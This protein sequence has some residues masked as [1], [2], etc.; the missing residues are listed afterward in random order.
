M[1]LRCPKCGRV[2]LYE[3]NPGTYGCPWLD[4]KLKGY[5]PKKEIYNG[6]AITLEE[7]E[8][9]KKIMKGIE[10]ITIPELSCIVAY[11]KSPDP[12]RDEATTKLINCFLAQRFRK[13]E[14]IV[15]EFAKDGIGKFPYGWIV[16]KHI[17]L[18]DDRPFNKSWL[19]NVGAR[20]ATTNNLIFHDADVLFGKDYLEKINEFRKTH[21]L[22]SGWSSFRCMPGRDNPH[23]RIHVPRTISCLIGA[24]FCNK[25]YYWNT[26]GG[27]NEDYFGYGREDSDIWHR[28]TYL[29][30]GI[31]VMDYPLVHYYHNWH[32]DSGPNP[33]I[34]EDKR[35]N[36]ILEKCM[37]NPEEI[38]QMLLKVK[39][40]N[41]EH[42]TLIHDE[43]YETE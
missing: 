18:Q 15:V 29:L 35:A 24:W 4:C 8:L 2:G 39:L 25:D 14:L 32:P 6:D 36:A 12:Q 9:H 40:G 16:D 26:F 11:A 10:K 19:M 41:M 42:P 13:F 20:V 34:R 28:A 37:K 3:T 22:F 33:L 7:K 43:N 27:Y 31:P 1:N 30:D 5:V 21:V 17:I 38:R 23:M